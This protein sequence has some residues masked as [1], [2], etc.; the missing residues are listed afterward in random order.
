MGAHQKRQRATGRGESGSFAAIPHALLKTRKYAT[1]SAWSVKLLVDMVGQYT[2]RNNGDLTA[3]WAVMSPKGWRSKGTLQRA[4]T[5]LL[6]AGFVIRTRYGGRNLCALYA[7]TW[8]PVDEC[9]DRVT[10]KPKLDVSPTNTQ[11]GGW[12]DEHEEVA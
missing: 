1:L 8:K 12:Q 5:D 9:L 6:A 10:R 2:G 4:L 11:P 7:I 3:S